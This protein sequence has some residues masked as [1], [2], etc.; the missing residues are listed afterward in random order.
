M[1]APVTVRA[2]GEANR[3]TLL[4]GDS[5]L[6]SVL[7]NGELLVVQQ[8]A[9]LARMASACSGDAE[10]SAAGQLIEVRKAFRDKATAES[11][12]ARLR[13]YRGRP[14]PGMRDDIDRWARLLT[15]ADATIRRVLGGAA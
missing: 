15:E 5:W 14:T 11:Q 1:T 12:L 3:Y 13:G 9:M 6:A 7:V 10:P 8:E 2:D 4:Q